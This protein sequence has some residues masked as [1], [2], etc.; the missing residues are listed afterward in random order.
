MF[1][2]KADISTLDELTTLA[3][4][5]WPDNSREYVRSEFEELLESEKD[6]FYLAFVEGVYV[7]F[8]HMSLRHDYVEGSHSSPVGYVEGIYVDHKYRRKGISKK[9]V[10]AGEQWSKSLGC[11]QMASDTQLDNDGSQQ[12]HKKIGFREA[13]R[14]VAFIKDL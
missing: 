13:G 2:V 11:S 10:E 6:I 14:I 12:F 4:K 5:L 3:L 7:G 8:I 1:I 9:L